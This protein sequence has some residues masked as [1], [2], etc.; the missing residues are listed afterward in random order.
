VH[1]RWPPVDDLLYGIVRRGI[2]PA[3]VV[4]QDIVFVLIRFD[5]CR[6]LRRS[7]LRRLDYIAPSLASRRPHVV[8]D[9][10]TGSRRLPLVATV[11]RSSF[12]VAIIL[13]KDDVRNA[14]VVVG[15][16]ASGLHPLDPDPFWRP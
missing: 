4:V 5:T 16:S 14:V 11:A 6:A 15:S 10:I 9:S 7:P 13:L 3:I 12:V 1:E 2:L 8:I